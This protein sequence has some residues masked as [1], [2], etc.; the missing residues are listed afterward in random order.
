MKPEIWTLEKIRNG[1]N[2]FY[3]AHSRYPTAYD[4]DDFDFL[5]SSRQIQ[6]RFGGLVNLRKE[7]GLKIKNY[8]EGKNRTE[9]SHRIVKEGRECENVVLDSLRNIFDEKF[10]HIEKPIIGKIDGY[11]SKDRYDFYVYAKPNNF[12]IDVFKTNDVRNLVNI[13]NIKEKKYKKTTNSEKLYFIYFGQDINQEKLLYWKENKKN[14][15]PENW[16]IINV[17]DFNKELTKYSSYKAL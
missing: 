7:L 5:P 10:I 8:G 4:V 1:F 17:N 9:V 11:D 15:F 2:K 3:E 16:E 13:L 14:K 6:R 12:A